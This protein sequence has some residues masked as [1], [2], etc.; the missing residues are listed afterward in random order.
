LNLRLFVAL[1]PPDPVRR[2]L[3][4]AQAALRAAAG[5]HADEIR[6][7]PADRLHL[8]LQFLGAVPE[9]RLPA[10][11]RAV[12][13]AAAASRPLRLAVRGTGAFPAPRRARVIWAGVEDD[14][15]GLAALAAGLGRALAP[16]GFAAEGR[17]LSPHVTF[18]RSRDA[19]GASGVG[20]A[21]ASTAGLEPIAW[22]ADAVVLFRSHLAA[23]GTRH[24]PLDRLPLG[25]AASPA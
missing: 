10:V 23:G 14:A 6:W 5:S 13:D 2:R 9:E 3:A 18:G 16:L 15:G 20:G 8:T 7:T 21:I 24:E 1:E 4:A 19:R 17:P 22:R 11:R 25:P 12:A